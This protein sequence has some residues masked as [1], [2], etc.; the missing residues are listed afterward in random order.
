M[1][2]LAS[3]LPTLASASE[4]ARPGTIMKF[5]EKYEIVEM[6]TSGRVC[7]FLARDRSTSEQTVVWTFE[8]AEE[9]VASDTSSIVAR[10]CSLA[11]NPPGMITAAG[12]DEQTCT[13]FLAT[14]VPA[15]QELDAWVS[16]YHS[17]SKA[18]AS[19]PALSGAD[20]SRQSS[21]SPVPSLDQT[22]P[23]T[24]GIF[25]SGPTLHDESNRASLADIPQQNR[26]ARPLVV[27][28]PFRASTR[29]P[30]RPRGGPAAEPET[31]SGPGAFTSFFQN[32]FQPAGA[33]IADSGPSANP[34]SPGPPGSFTQIFGARGSSTEPRPGSGTLDEEMS[35]RSPAFSEPANLSPAPGSFTQIFVG[36]G[37]ASEPG[38][39]SPPDPES[40]FSEPANPPQAPGSFTQIFG[41]G[42]P[43][44]G[45]SAFESG[46]VERTPLA[47]SVFAKPDSPA[48]SPGSF[49]QIF[50]SAKPAFESGPSE[51]NSLADSVFAKPASRAPS[52]GSFTQV[53]GGETIAPEAL[54]VDSHPAGDSLFSD[55]VPAAP[56]QPA[57]GADVRT[58]PVPVPS[59]PFSP[60]I[61]ANPS[62]SIF[63]SAN[64]GATNEVAA[65]PPVLAG[66]APPAEQESRPRSEFTMFMDRNQVRAMLAVE[67]EAGEKAEATAGKPGFALPPTVPVPATKPM[68][69]APNITAP[70]PAM[71]ALAAPPVPATA[72]S[73]S[74]WPLITVL[75]GLLAIGALLVMYFAMKR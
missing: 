75:V 8:C 5:I 62:P 52:P 3:P 48:Q 55:P 2:F 18:A 16:A 9:S 29:T 14:R 22:T 64:N 66:D 60:R 33:P 38:I 19:K 44:P 57:I 40:V 1:L 27:E 6:L 20:V 37:S 42:G 23:S 59:D 51:H 35:P 41:S 30:D 10:F 73:G 21:V 32:P 13:A 69:P 58:E 39:T 45:K 28:E 47:D 72:K 36:G 61:P 65:V 70:K 53:F 4:I 50:G 25:S 67:P 43:G 34:A 12:F 31:G 54:P 63:P 71:P 56:V 68:P 11:P 24:S 17:F 46:P 49:T 74:I 15:P 7:T 26:P